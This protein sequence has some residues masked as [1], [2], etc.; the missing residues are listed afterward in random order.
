MPFVFDAPELQQ[1]TTPSHM[2]QANASVSAA[3]SPMHNYS[4]GV[5]TVGSPSLKGH[6]A[7]QNLKGPLRA[8]PDA[9]PFALAIRDDPRAQQQIHVEPPALVATAFGG[10]QFSGL[11]VAQTAAQ[12]GVSPGNDYKVGTA[13]NDTFSLLAG[14]DVGL[15]EGGDDT[16]NGNEGEDIL[17]GGEGNDTLVGGQQNDRLTGSAGNDI[18]RGGEGDDQ[19]FGGDGNDKLEGGNGNDELEGH[20]GADTLNGDAGD[21]FLRA[22]PGVDQMRGGPGFDTYILMIDDDPVRG[23]TIV[24]K[25]P[26]AL[27]FDSAIRTADVNLR[28]DGADLIVSYRGSTIRVIGG[29]TGGDLGSVISEL[30]FGNHPPISIQDFKAG[31]YVND[32]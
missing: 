26:N 12:A 15:G 30:K 31:K 8:N 10:H 20:A 28:A 11:S 21:D 13:G 9:S 18:L 23:S 14:D 16:L 6:A 29:A 19:L 17:D 5:L 32:E 4:E 2:E 7:L 22:G 1:N 24:D 25:A 3:C 27:F